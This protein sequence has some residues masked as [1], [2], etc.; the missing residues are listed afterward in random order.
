MITLPKK[1]DDRVLALCVVT[2]LLGIFPLPYGFYTITRIVFFGSL[3][4]FGIQSFGANKKFF[5][6]GLG[7]FLILA[8]ILYNPVFQIHLGSRVVWLVLNVATLYLIWRIIES[9][10]STD[11]AVN[12]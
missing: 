10:K 6:S 5:Y 2:V 7:V 4:W 12:N 1:T 8:A 3:L 11:K 9:L